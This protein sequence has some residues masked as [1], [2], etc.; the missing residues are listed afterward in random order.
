MVTQN[1]IVAAVK[2]A[3]LRKYPQEA[4]YTNIT[5]SRFDRP[6]FLVENTGISVEASTGGTVTLQITVHVVCFENVD[7]YH[8]SQLETLNV[9]QLSILGIFAPLHLKVTDRALDVV[10]LTGTAGGRDWIDVTAV[11][12]WDE[13]L[14]D[15]Q[16][17]KPLPEMQEINLKMEGST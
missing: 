13:D 15:F 14:A 5:P 2:A 4:V 1:D 3:I 12:E 11:L 9:R 7:E 16:N 17:I 10:K 8:N 6:A